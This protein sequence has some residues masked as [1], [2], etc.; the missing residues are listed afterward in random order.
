MEPFGVLDKTLFSSGSNRE[1]KGV[2]LNQIVDELTKKCE[3]LAV[4]I[5]DWQGLSFASKLPKQVN[6]EEISA[7]TLFT[8]EGAEGTRKELE[9]TL[10]GKKLSY[11]ILVTERLGKPAYMI[12]FP[13]EDLGYIACISHIR[14][15]MA[16]IIQ[17][18]KAAS[19]KAAEILVVSEKGD[20]CSLDTIEQLIAPKYDNL[21]K[22]LDALKNVK[23][24][25]L[26]KAPAC[27]PSNTPQPVPDSNTF[28]EPPEI[29]VI[30]GPPLPPE[31]PLDFIEVE[32]EID[33]GEPDII[34]GPPPQK[35][36][37]TFRDAKQ[38]KY[39]VVLSAQ[40]E[41]DAE[42]RI[43]DREQFQD[44]DIIEIV[45]LDA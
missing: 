2:L 4:I 33:E 11:L 16:V 3:V 21:M 13:I 43:R 1:N 29:P 10:L 18:M 26:E 36:Q 17:N 32:T 44:V 7:T 31:M 28:P 23:L 19:K 5:A 34:P 35:F 8:L 40:N 9:K 30:T 37:V 45:K 38:I 41:L 22:K 6:E 12:I 42:V 25:F 14:E 27:D 39:T 20:Q 24:P 15:D